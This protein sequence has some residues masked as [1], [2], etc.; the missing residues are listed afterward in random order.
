MTQGQNAAAFDEGRAENALP[1]GSFG[2]VWRLQNAVPGMSW[3]RAELVGMSFVVNLFALGLPIFILQVYDRVLPNE[4]LTTMQFLVIGLLFVVVLDGVMKMARS[5]VTTWNGARFEHLARVTAV[6][7]VLRTQTDRY[8]RET[9]GTFFDRIHSLSAVKEFYATNIA[10]LM[11]DV[12]FALLFLVLIGYLGGALVLAPIALITIFAILAFFIGGA[13]RKSVSERS[14]LDNQRYD[15]MIEIIR[16]IQTVKALA[17]K[18]LM[19]RRFEQLQEHSAKA[20]HDVALRSSLAQGLGALFSQLNMVCVIG[21][22]AIMVLDG[23]L[24]AGELA[25]CTLLSGRAMQPLQ[26]AMGLWTSFQTIRVSGARAAEVMNLPDESPEDLPDLPDIQGEVEL[27]GVQFSYNGRAPYFID[28]MNLNLKAGEVIGIEG[29][30]SSGRSTLL[31]LIMGM[32]KPQGGR[33]TVDGHD[34]SHYRPESIRQQIAYLA[35]GSEVYSGTIIDNLTNFRDGPIIER[36]IDM[37]KELGIDEQVKRMPD[38]YDTNVGDGA[39]EML[40]R[41]FRQRI[42]IV[43]ALVDRPKVILFDEANQGLDAQSDTLLRKLLETLKGKSTIVI[44]SHRPALLRIADRR[45]SM[46][47]GKLGPWVDTYGAIQQTAQPKPAAPQPVAP[48]AAAPQPA[49]PQPAAPKPPAVQPAPQVAPPPP[50]PQQPAQRG[51]Q[52]PPQMAQ[53]A[54]VPTAPKPPAAAPRPKAPV[55]RAPAPVQRAARPAV[56]PPGQAAQKAVAAPQKAAPQ[57][58]VARKPA[59][60]QVAA[61]PARPAKAPAQ[62]AAKAPTPVQKR[63]AVTRPAVQKPAPTPQEPPKATPVAQAPKPAQRATGAGAPSRPGAAALRATQSKGPKVSTAAPIKAAPGA[64][65]PQAPS[66]GTGPQKKGPT[67]SAGAKPVKPKT[68]A[69]RPAAK[70]SA[71]PANPQGGTPGAGGRA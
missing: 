28:G 56:P 13:L 27:Q 17:L 47:D 51:A 19:Q 68:I 15:F 64:T 33:V 35:Q 57:K 55:Q 29:D 53:R 43:R 40:P 4:G 1:K 20:V 36:A 67:V 61:A 42:A 69:R 48:Q 45:F 39:A 11:I 50:P 5:Y 70:P 9:P 6:Q 21:A 52:T 2:D 32:L 24:S 22:G 71:R 66:A 46:E 58:Q 49:A 26:S 41:G 65:A 16:G 7:R 34:L 10:T 59:P 14:A 12:P 44:V 37:A 3:Y 60:P 25:A 31:L 8:E 62:V 18:P 23:T 54:P 63:P 38:G 30:N